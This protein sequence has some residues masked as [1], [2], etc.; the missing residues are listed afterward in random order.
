MSTAI[1]K[2]ANGIIIVYDIT[3]PKSFE[4]LDGWKKDIKE[5]CSDDVQVII[6]GNKKDLKEE[7]RITEE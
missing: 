5:I 1:Y 4:D 6:L 7:R 3:N 2:N